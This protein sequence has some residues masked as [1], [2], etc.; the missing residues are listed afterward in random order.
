[1]RSV[2]ELQ[3]QTLTVR[4]PEGGIIVPVQYKVEEATRGMARCLELAN[5]PNA[6][7]G[8]CQVRETREEYIAHAM[9]WQAIAISW[10]SR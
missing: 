9:A 5:D 6:P 8:W 1:M 10:A 2:A 3:H 7:L 4:H